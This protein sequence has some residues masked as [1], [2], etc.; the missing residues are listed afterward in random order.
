MI[1]G[2]S[3]R[4]DP[5]VIASTIIQLICDELA[6]EDMENDSQFMTLN[7]KLQETKRER[8]KREKAEKKF[9]QSGRKM[10]ERKDPTIKSKFTNKYHER[11]ES[12]KESEKK[13]KKK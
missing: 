8:K 9:Q 3:I 10:F 12:I 5:D 1:D 13:S 4:H 6:F 2:D 7:A 11:I